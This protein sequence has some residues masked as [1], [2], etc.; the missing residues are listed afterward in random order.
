[1]HD[2]TGSVLITR[3]DLPS[4]GLMSKVEAFVEPS[5]NPSY[6]S[7]DP[8]MD[9][10]SDIYEEGPEKED[11]DPVGLIKPLNTMERVDN[12][13]PVT[14]DPPK[15]QETENKYA[16]EIAKGLLLYDRRMSMGVCRPIPALR[17]P[18]TAVFVQSFTVL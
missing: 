7:K 2:V 11:E 5:E 15:F 1:M 10:G 6:H 13:S 9:A 8:A 17:R 4:N 14:P 16:T 12:P 18:A 3:V